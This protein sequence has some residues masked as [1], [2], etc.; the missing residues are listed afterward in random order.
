MAAFFLVRFRVKEA[1]HEE[2]KAELGVVSRQPTS[3]ARSGEV[4]G[5]GTSVNISGKEDPHDDKG[6]SNVE[7][8]DTGRDTQQRSTPNAIFSELPIFST[9]PHLEQVGPWR[10]HEPPIA[11]LDHCHLL[12]MMLSAIGF[13]LAMVGIMCY[14]WAKLPL[15]SRVVTSVF[16]G[17]C[18]A[19]GFAAIFAPVSFAPV[20]RA[21]QSPAMSPQG[22]PTLDEQQRPFSDKLPGPRG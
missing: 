20:S 1:Q 8:G 3:Q 14:V 19:L 11:L 12:C 7:S 13:I 2:V 4:I 5:D 15:S 6:N 18:I 16:G 21:L 10:K 22:L 17:F 9:D